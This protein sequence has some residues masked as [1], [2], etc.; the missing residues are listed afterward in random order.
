MRLKGGVEDL[1]KQ[2]FDRAMIHDVEE[3]SNGYLTVKA[4]L[5]KP[6]VYPYQRSDGSIQYELKH[7]D[8][9]FGD[10]VIQGVIAKPVTDGHPNEKV[11]LDNVKAYGKGFSHTDSGVRHNTVMVTITVFDK[12]LISDIQD[13]RKREISLGFETDLVAEP[14]TYDGQDYQYRQTNIDVNHIAIVEHGR[15]GPEASIRNDSMAWEV[16]NNENDKG[17]RTDMP[18]IKLDGKDYEVDPVVKSRVD[19]LEAKLE[20]AEERN[21]KV[22]SLEGTNDAL[23]KKVK[24]LE[25]DLDEAKKNQMSQDSLDKAVQERVVLVDSARTYLGDDYDFT[26]KTDKDIKVAVIQTADSEFKADEKSED[27]INAFYDATVQKVKQDGFTSTGANTLKTGSGQTKQ[28]TY[29]DMRAKRM[30]V[31]ENMKNQ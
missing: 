13:G 22:D 16:E 10:Q 20:T 27:Y 1:K 21:K 5:V 9:I 28:E 18:T 17:G 25:S 29:D 23:D 14:G 3:Q 31:K 8:D 6:G 15:V 2:R 24:K 30:N 11:D 26:G 19:T 7:P 4:S 12:G